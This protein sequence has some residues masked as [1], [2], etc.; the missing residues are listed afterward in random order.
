MTERELKA[1]S[2]SIAATLWQTEPS[3]QGKSTNELVDW[4]VSTAEPIAA[5]IRNTPDHEVYTEPTRPKKML[6]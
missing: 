6:P 3:N 2:M 1:W 5:E 4:L